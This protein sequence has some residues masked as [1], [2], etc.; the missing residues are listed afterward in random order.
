MNDDINIQ[1]EFPD[2]LRL[3][4][5]HRWSSAFATVHLQIFSTNSFELTRKKIR[6]SC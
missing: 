1:R 2:E 6:N 3:R 4:H 5:P